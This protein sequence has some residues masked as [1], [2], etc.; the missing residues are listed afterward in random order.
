[1]RANDT[2][3]PGAYLTRAL[4]GGMRPFRYRSGVYRLLGLPDRRA[5]GV[6]FLPPLPPVGFQYEKHWRAESPWTPTPL[7][8][9]ARAHRQGAPAGEGESEGEMASADRERKPME[10]A[11]AATPSL[12]GALSSEQNPFGNRTAPLEPWPGEGSAAST[13]TGMKKRTTGDQKSSLESS[14]RIIQ[15]GTQSTLSEAPAPVSSPDSPVTLGPALA[16]SGGLEIP[17][18]TQR[19]ALFASLARHVSTRDSAGVVPS[20]GRSGSRAHAGTEAR[21]SGLTDSM[22]ARGTNPKHHTELDGGP[23]N[24]AA[25]QAGAVTPHDGSPIAD[26][27]LASHRTVE[28]TSPSVFRS[29]RRMRDEVEHVRRAVATRT[30]RQEA[31]QDATPRGTP[32]PSPAAAPPIAPP[33]IVVRQIIGPSRRVSRAFW[34][35]SIL[36]ST[37][38]R[39]LR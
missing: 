19:R 37:H 34:G 35:S 24:K 13:S 17:G 15:E 36:R 32:P 12:V 16:P 3:M 8:I 25:L 14:D 28:E 27:M 22:R 29:G 1:M 7:Q 21:S 6:T 9:P 2:S 30:V 20:A 33:S 10:S 38:L 31:A 4:A 26:P 23:R 5:E 18:I 11:G 39:I